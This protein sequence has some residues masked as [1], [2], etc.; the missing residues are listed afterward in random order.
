VE[1]EQQQMGK[2][3]LMPRMQHHCAEGKTK[4]IHPKAVSKISSTG[5]ISVRPRVN[6]DCRYE[7][8]RHLLL[9]IA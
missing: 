9:Q 3:E 7:P 2:N 4:A 8:R 1:K 5:Q 6:T